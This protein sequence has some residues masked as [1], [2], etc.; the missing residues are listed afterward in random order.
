[1]D[2]RINNQIGSIRL[3]SNFCIF[4]IGLLFMPFGFF[5]GTAFAVATNPSGSMEGGNQFPT[6]QPGEGDPGNQGGAGGQGDPG[7]QDPPDG[8]GQDGDPGFPPPVI[9]PVDG[10]FDAGFDAGGA[11]QP[12]G[13]ARHKIS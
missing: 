4:L 5:S 2:S 7:I 3:P 12:G 1:M 11:V 13:H 8:Q 10:G 9:V 6:D